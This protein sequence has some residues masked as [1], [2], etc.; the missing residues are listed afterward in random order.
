MVTKDVYCI[1]RG[2]YDGVEFMIACDRCEEWFHGRCI[3]M[4]PQEAKKSNH[5]YCDT[6]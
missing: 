2:P 6:C 4:K 1:C 5:Y 3:G